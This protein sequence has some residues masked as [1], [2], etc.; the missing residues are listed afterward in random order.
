MSVT[1]ESVGSPPV[2]YVNVLHLDSI[3]DV[4]S[5]LL[6]IEELCV[7]AFGS[8]RARAQLIGEASA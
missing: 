3:D 7:R 1:I 8:E 6:H 5:D 4:R 2:L